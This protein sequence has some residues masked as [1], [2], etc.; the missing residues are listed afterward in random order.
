MNPPAPAITIRS[1]L[2]IGE[3]PL[4]RLEIVAALKTRVGDAYTTTVSL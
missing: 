2:V 4:V 1:F 3:I